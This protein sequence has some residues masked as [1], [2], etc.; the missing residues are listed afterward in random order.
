MV[1]HEPI[2]VS[3]LVTPWNFPAAMATR[4]LGAGAGGGLHRAC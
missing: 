4:K 1:Q 2:G 3:V